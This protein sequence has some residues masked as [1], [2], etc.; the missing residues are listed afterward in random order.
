MSRV[1][2]VVFILLGSSVAHSAPGWYRGVIDR[3]WTYGGEGDFV[4]TF[5]GDS[6]TSD[7][8][9][10]Y[11]SFRA[12]DLQPALMKNAYSLALSAFHSNANVGVVID[13]DLNGGNCHALS[14]DIIK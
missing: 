6:T 3:I 11:I 4:I 12:A 10:N 1:L 8:T 9:H 14:I 5:Q 7:C 13:K 2:F